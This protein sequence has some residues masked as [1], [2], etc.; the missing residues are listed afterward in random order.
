MREAALLDGAQA[1]EVRE[2]VSEA[3]VTRCALATAYL[4]AVA[5][6]K[7]LLDDGVSALSMKFAPPTVSTTTSTRKTWAGGRVPPP[8][9]RRR[10][11]G[12]GLHRPT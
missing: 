10:A 5:K 4:P 9:W 12:H 3:G 2:A 11:D 1:D 8:S 6:A 7:Q